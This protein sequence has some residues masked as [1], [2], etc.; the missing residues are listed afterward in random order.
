M[1]DGNA[2][3]NRRDFVNPG[4]IFAANSTD[5]YA[6]SYNSFATNGNGLPA[7]PQPQ[8]LASDARLTANNQL[9][10]F[11]DLPPSAPGNK[12]DMHILK[13]SE[14]Q[15]RFWNLGKIVQKG[16]HV[17][18]R[19]TTPSVP[20]INGNALVFSA[21]GGPAISADLQKQQPAEVAAA[22]EKPAN[23]DGLQ[24][25]EGLNRRAMAAADADS[26]AVLWKVLGGKLVKSS[27][28]GQ[29]E[30]AYPGAGFQF[31]IVTARG[32][33]VWAGGT[34]A[35]VIHSHDG[36]KTWEAAKLGDAASG[37]VMNILFSGNIVQVKTSEDQSWLS[38]DGGKSW[39]QN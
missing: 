36:G 37:T 20:A 39:A 14:P 2:G 6:S 16:A 17:V 19:H 4:I 35:S 32:N 1:L 31:A 22:P 15:D 38:S 13:S 18:L 26:T 30:D 12:S 27:G 7:A 34:Q 23:V 10:I 3:G 25:F 21:M 8:P 29:W 5:N 28:P 11:K 9:T 24:R 33:E